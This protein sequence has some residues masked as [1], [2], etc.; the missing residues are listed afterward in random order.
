MGG[1][2]GLIDSF[3]GASGAKAASAAGRLQSE[4]TLAGVDETRRQF[5]IT[6]GNLAPIL[7]TGNLA[8][9][10]QAALLGLSGQEAQN[11]AF[12]AFNESPGQAFLRNRQERALLRNTAAIGGLGGGNVRTALQQQAVGNAQKDFGNQFNRLAGI[13]GAGQTATATGGQLGAQSSNQ[14]AQLLGQ[15]AQAQASGIL[16]A[17]QSRAAGM[18]RIM[19]G[20]GGAA[21]GATGALGSVGAGGGALVGLL[22]DK[23]KKTD[24][25]DLSLKECFDTVMTIPLKSWRY[26]EQVGLGTDV[27]LGPLAQ[28]A[29]DIMKIE[30][31][32]A[33]DLH[34]ELM[35]VVGALQ[36]MQQNEAKKCH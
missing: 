8:R 26:L 23:N 17:E 20:L 16:G 22:S 10:Q 12:A 13:S 31:M 21:L 1:L 35:L 34:N 30:G 36:Y 5:D 33:L 28:E 27:N 25:N 19:G 29:P 4:A 15:G 18:G 6:Q 9:D 2:S 32:E 24:I 7:E 14:I 3:T 11:A